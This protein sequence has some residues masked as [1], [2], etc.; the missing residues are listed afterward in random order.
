MHTLPT[1]TAL[2]KTRFIDLHQDMLS[3]VAQLDGGFPMY[4]SNYLTG[5]SHAAAV[6]SSLFPH[7]PGSC[8]ISQLA[9]H[10]ELLGSHSSSLRLVTTVAD[11]DADDPRTGVLPHSEGFHLPAIGPDA[12]NSLWAEHSLRS[13]ALTWNYETDYGFSCYD[14]GAAPLKPTGRQLVRALEESPLLLDLAHLND[15]GFYEVL[16]LYGPPVLVTHTFCKGITDHPRGLADEQLRTLGDH[17][18]LVGLAFDPDFLGQGLIDE[19]LRH[20]DRIATLAGEDAVSIG[21][22]WGVVPMGELGDHAA[23]AGLLDAVGTSYGPDLAEKF[24]FANAYDFLRAQLPL[25]RG[26]A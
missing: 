15:A 22:D 8:L 23:L 26:F 5:S 11:L 17:G 13:L 3:G 18:G 9:A 21:S 24:A 7:T 12:L 20:V 1:H 10:D 14:D 19:A 4:G 2:Q 25:D 6:W 16:D